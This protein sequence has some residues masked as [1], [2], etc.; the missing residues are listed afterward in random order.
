[1]E[2][3]ICSGNEPARTSPTSALNRSSSM[4]SRPSLDIDNSTHPPS[5]CY[6]DAHPV[7]LSPAS[8]K[9]PTSSRSHTLPVSTSKRKREDRTSVCSTALAASG[10][11]F[12]TVHE[13]GG[14]EGDKKHGVLHK[15]E[16]GLHKARPYV[17]RLSGTYE[18]LPV[19]EPEHTNMD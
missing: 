4:S 14:A 17:E 19:K 1:M 16:A 18:P 12:A 2:P 15:I 7:P 6:E 8:P 5:T 13:S 9:S 11:S 10:D 3:A